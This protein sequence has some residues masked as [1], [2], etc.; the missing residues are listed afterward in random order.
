MRDYHELVETV[1]LTDDDVSAVVHAA[2]ADNLYFRIK[3]IQLSVS[4]AASEGGILEFLDSVGDLVWAINVDE[5]K[6][7]RFEFGKKGV[8]VG[9]NTG[10]QAVL[11]GAVTQATVS[12]CVI[13]HLSVD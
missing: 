9:Q 12:V 13:A 3:V 10:I 1:V 7:I 5:K 4:K 2:C 8:T 11:S 6:D